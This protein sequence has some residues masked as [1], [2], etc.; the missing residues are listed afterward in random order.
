MP[1]LA[2][3]RLEEGTGGTDIILC[4]SHESLD[5]CGPPSLNAE[6]SQGQSRP[7]TSSH[8]TLEPLE[9][10]VEPQPCLDSS[11]S[12]WILQNLQVIETSHWASP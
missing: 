4:A 6:S 10:T 3:E 5:S 9:E 7:Y 12:L 2:K 11:L 8:L 1:G